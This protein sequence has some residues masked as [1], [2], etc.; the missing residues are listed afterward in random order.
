MA[1][2]SS[3]ILFILQ[4][5]AFLFFYNI[6]AQANKTF[7]A[8]FSFGDS[9]L[10][11]GMNNNLLSGRCNYPPY[12]R[13][14][15]GKV[16]TGRFCNG[17]NPT[18][19]IAEAL[20]IKDIVPA[21][22][23]PDLQSDDLLT[24]VGF[25]SGGSGIDPL[26]SSTLGVVAMSQQ[27]QYFKD[28]IGKLTGVA[29]EE[30]AKAIVANSLVLMSAGNND[31]GVS[32][33]AGL[34]KLEYTFPAYCAQLVTWSTTF[35]EQLYALGARR[36]GVLSTVA[37]GCEPS[38]RFIRGSSCSMVANLGAQ[39]YN[40]LLKVGI[41]SLQSKHPDAKLVFFDIF[42]PLVNIASNPQQFGFQNANSGCCG[43]FGLCLPFSPF[44]CSDA[45]TYVFWDFVHPTEKTYRIIVSDVLN[46]T[47]SSFS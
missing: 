17:K 27:L 34:R 39:M 28:Y 29:G 33:T 16:A 30:K 11:T 41:A 24:G 40:N 45:S 26:T 8:I 20:G 25:A 12:G 18:D 32:Y 15:P 14:F 23:K 2:A 10:D 9:I 4:A 31:I 38:A 37:F 46:K 13:D 6:G 42:T 19:L 21:Y 7:S 3:F 36:F 1:S 43:G 22:L 5:C 44:A 47:L 35:L